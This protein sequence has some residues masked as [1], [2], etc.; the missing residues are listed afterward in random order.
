M[1]HP[2]LK[3]AFSNLYGFTSDEQGIRHALID[4]PQVKR[5]SGRSGV[6]ARRLRIVQQLP[7]SKAPASGS[8]EHSLDQHTMTIDIPALMTSIQCWRRHHGSN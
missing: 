8:P 1:L 3:R 2:A 7:R 6:H 4:N 5:R